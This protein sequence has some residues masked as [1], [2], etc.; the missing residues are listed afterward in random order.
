M[1][2]RLRNKPSVDYKTLHEGE[3]LPS[4]NKLKSKTSYRVLPDSYQ[5][6]RILKRQ[7]DSDGVSIV[8]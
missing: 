4:F 3:T 1:A 8:L 5:V 6:D 2:L 7:N